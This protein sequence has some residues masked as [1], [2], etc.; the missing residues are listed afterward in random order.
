MSETVDNQIKGEV[1]LEEAIGIKGKGSVIEVDPQTGKVTVSQKEEKRRKKDVEIEKEHDEICKTWAKDIGQTAEVWF[2]QCLR[3]SAAGASQTLVLIEPLSTFFDEEGN[4]TEDIERWF[5]YRAEGG[6][7]YVCQ[8]RINGKALTN[9]PV[10]KYYYKEDGEIYNELGGFGE[11]NSMDKKGK[12]SDTGA[13]LQHVDRTNRMIM[14]MADNK[15][16]STDPSIVQS[17]AQALV[18]KNGG[19]GGNS[20]IIGL[21]SI[22]MQE[23]AKTLQTTLQAIATQPKNDDKG[24]FIEMFRSVSEG[25]KEMGRGTNESINKISQMMLDMNRMMLEMQTRSMELRSNDKVETM[26]MMAGMQE[27]MLLV[28]K[29]MQVGKN[30]N[31][32]TGF[33]TVNKILEQAFKTQTLTSGFNTQ[34]MGSLMKSF[35]D[36][37]GVMKELNNLKGGEDVE[38]EE[39]ETVLEKLTNKVLDPNFI[40]AGAKFIGSMRGGNQFPI[41]SNISGSDINEKENTVVSENIQDVPKNDEMT[42]KE[43]L[44]DI[45]EDIMGYLEDKKSHEEIAGGVVSLYGGYKDKLISILNKNK[46]ELMSIL[47]GE[48]LNYIIKNFGVMKSILGLIKKKLT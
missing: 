37:I 46:D 6:F 33:D 45:I 16:D 31:D 40:A 28:V 10:R 41:N 22:M 24:M 29:E 39:S 35:T 12:D 27:K 44:N 17:L 47:N 15:K 9:Q 5:S 20:D 7:A 4:S 21:M 18:S 23:N 30:P 34:L 43:I 3:N 13:I 38:E 8:L 25:M 1:G 11:N 2:Y 19:S 36:T 26:K 32:T 42:E 48:N 14:D